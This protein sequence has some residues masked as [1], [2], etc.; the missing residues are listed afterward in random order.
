MDQTPSDTSILVS[1]LEVAADSALDQALQARA[2]D[3]QGSTNSHMARVGQLLRIQSRLKTGELI[4]IGI[5][6]NGLP[7]PALLRPQIGPRS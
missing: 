2:K 6:V 5:S 7:Q 1:A 3:D 4:L